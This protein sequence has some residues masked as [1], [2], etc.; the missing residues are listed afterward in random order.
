MQ[1]QPE[2]HLRLKWERIRRG[3][4]QVTV[5]DLTGLLQPQISQFERGL[6]PDPQQLQKLADLFQVFPPEK[7]L[8]SVTVSVDERAAAQ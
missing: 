7:L 6:I 8:E 2:Q 4:K 3:W 5:A 1:S